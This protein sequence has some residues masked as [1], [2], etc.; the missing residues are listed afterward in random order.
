LIEDTFP[1][2]PQVVPPSNEQLW[3]SERSHLGIGT[4]I[5]LRR[6]SQKLRREMKGRSRDFSPSSGCDFE[7]IIEQGSSTDQL[8][9]GG[10]PGYLF[11]REEYE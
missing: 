9:R 1:S 5:N 4:E 7:M 2:F 8:H 6:D 11:S 3:S 10:R